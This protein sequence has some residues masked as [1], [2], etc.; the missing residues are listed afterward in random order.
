MGSPKGA[1]KFGFPSIGGVQES[2]ASAGHMSAALRH[3]GID[4]DG[5][6]EVAR[7]DP[8]GQRLVGFADL[9][10]EKR[11]HAEA[12]GQMKLWPG[13]LRSVKADGFKDEG[14]SFRGAPHPA[15]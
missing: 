3:T 4:A 14:L 10:P 5:T 11:S 1:E 12:V 6:V 15:Q 2:D 8:K 7:F 9:L 13:L